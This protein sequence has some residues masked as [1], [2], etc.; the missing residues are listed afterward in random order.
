M[1]VRL[2]AVS[3]RHNEHR[4]IWAVHHE[5]ADA[6]PFPVSLGHPIRDGKLVA[7][8]DAH[9]E[10]HRHAKLDAKYDSIRDAKCYFDVNS[11]CFW[12]PLA[13]HDAKCFAFRDGIAVP[14]WRLHSQRDAHSQR[15]T[16]GNDNPVEQSDS[17]TFVYAQLFAFA[18]I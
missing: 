8:A 7:D 10:S 16:L 9:G 6:E 12:Q 14:H 4:G 17:D 13:E 5:L 1:C 18:N 11:V 2:Y 3:S 15:N